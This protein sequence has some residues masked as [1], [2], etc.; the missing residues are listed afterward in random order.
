M[1][2]NPRKEGPSVSETVEYYNSNSRAF[3]R[4]TEA[5]DLSALH[6]RFLA[7]LPYP[8]RILDAGSGAGRD[9][10]EFKH[11]GHEVLAIDASIKM[12]ESTRH[13]AAVPTEHTSFLDYSP[14]H[15]FDGIW[16]CAS[17][18]HVP[19]ER[20]PVTLNHM[21]GLLRPGG[22][23]FTS[24]KLGTSEGIR[25]GR[26]YRDL[27][28]SLFENLVE[29]LPTLT[30]RDVWITGDNRP[31]RVNEFWLNGLLIKHE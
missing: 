4:E 28:Q 16:A 18:L 5:V 14:G 2:G 8:A 12:V 7:D 26:F 21:A 29:Q 25:D 30:I 6:A 3:I 1:S 20:L 31:E 22:T 24:F 27:D 23:M 10:L 13:L 15:Q 17:L 11:R 19:M 9:A